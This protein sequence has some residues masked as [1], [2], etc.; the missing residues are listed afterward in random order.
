MIELDK[1]RW[2]QVGIAQSM[3]HRWREDPQNPCEFK[4]GFDA[5]LFFPPTA[6]YTAVAPLCEWIEETTNWEVRCQDWPKDHW[7]GDG[8]KFGKI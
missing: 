4:R 7:P 6:V 2:F 8:E 1:G 3:I 5:I